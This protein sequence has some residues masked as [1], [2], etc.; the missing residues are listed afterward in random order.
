[1]SRSDADNQVKVKVDFSADNK[2]KLM[3]LYFSLF[4]NINGYSYN[5]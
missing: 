4:M 3:K 1:M 2:W 5:I